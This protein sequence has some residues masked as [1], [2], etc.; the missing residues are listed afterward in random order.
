MSINEWIKK[1]MMIYPYNEI[2][3]NNVKG[4]TVDI[5]DDIT[6]SQNNYAKRKKS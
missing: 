2:H 6:E 1:R 3:L 5:D 4:W